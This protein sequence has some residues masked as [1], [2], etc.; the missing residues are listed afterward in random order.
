MGRLGIGIRTLLLGAALAASGAAHEDL[1]VQIDRLTGQIE[2]D[3]GRAILYF[4]RGELRRMHED[5]VSA[6]ED[7]E[8]AA[9]LDPALAVADLALGRLANQSGD[10]RRAKAALDRF[11]TREPDHGEALIERGRARV[12]LG[13]RS[14]AVEDFTRGLRTLEAPR[15]ENYLERA[16]VLRSEGRLEEALKG[17]QEGL[18]RVGTALPLQLALLDLELETSRFDAALARLDDVARAS[19]RKDLWLARRGDILR[20][21]G[22]KSEANRAYA[23]ALAA[24]EALPAARRRTRFTQ[25]LELKVRTA[26]EATNEKP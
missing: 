15:P 19:D 18:D 11:L 23:S 22:R 1:L 25:D 21:A 5:W 4:R 7:L 16:D 12:L 13:E 14:A 9:A 10:P 2:K 6:R 8:R 20:Q 3:P 17:L 24:I 26:L